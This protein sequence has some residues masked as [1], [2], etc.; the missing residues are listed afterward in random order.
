MSMDTEI[1][2]DNLT[3]LMNMGDS[4]SFADLF[5]PDFMANHTNF[6][7]IQDLF[8]KSGY[9]VETEEDFKAIP[10][11]EW[12]DFITENTSFESWKAM[13]LKAFEVFTDNVLLS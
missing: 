6:K 10:D 3:Q 5:S 2:Q 8:K 4:I 12:E 1:N 13:Q 9:S 7:T 11:E